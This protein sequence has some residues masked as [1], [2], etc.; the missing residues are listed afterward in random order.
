VFLYMK[1]RFMCVMATVWGAWTGLMW[2]GIGNGGWALVDA[3][4]NF[5]IP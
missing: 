1:I 3:A 4:I 5:R 2:L